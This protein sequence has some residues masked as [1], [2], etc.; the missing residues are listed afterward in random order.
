MKGKNYVGLFKATGHPLE[1]PLSRF[2][3]ENEPWILSQGATVSFRIIKKPWAEAGVLVTHDAQ[4][5][6]VEGALRQEMNRRLTA[7]GFKTNLPKFDRHA[8]GRILT[9]HPGKMIEILGWA[10]G[11][12]AG[13]Q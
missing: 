12:N 1:E 13:G 9:D 2:L 6:S 5:E 11:A 7:A 8:D 10:T 4:V 3:L